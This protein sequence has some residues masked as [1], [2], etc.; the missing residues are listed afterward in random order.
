MLWIAIALIPP[1]LHSFANVLDNYMANK[2][3][4]NVWTLTFYSSSF[5]VLFLPFIFLIERP[6]LPPFH[7]LPFIGLIALLEVFYLWPYY[8]ALQNDDTSVVTSLFDLGKIFVPLLA[9][10]IVGE[11]LSSVQYIGF[12][13]IILGS[14]LLTLSHHGK[15]RL[16]RSFFYMLLCSVLLSFEAVLYKYIFTSVDWSTGFVWPTIFSF[17][18]VLCFLLVPKQRRDIHL[19]FKKFENKISIFALEELLTFGGS[20]VAVFVISRIPVTLEEGISSFQPLFVLL[21]AMLFKPFFPSLF[22]E[23][24]DRRNVFHKLILFAVMIVGIVLVIR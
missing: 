7:L 5:G 18:I 4:K 17:G 14:A 23:H 20:A 3:S 1:L 16:N 2:L 22:R 19:Q 24:I 11:K 13:V 8:K 15:L 6:S 10:L 21:A 9:F 12:F